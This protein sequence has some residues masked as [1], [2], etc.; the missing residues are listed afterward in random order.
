MKRLTPFGAMLA[1]ALTLAACDS[2]GERTLG[3]DATGVVAGLAGVDRGGDGQLGSN[4]TPMRDLEVVLRS[5][6]GRGV[7]GRTITRVNGVF[8][9]ENVPVGEY[10]VTVMPAA[11]PD[12]LVLLRVDSAS[13]RLGANDTTFA[14]VILTYPTVSLEAARTAPLGQSM[15]IEG[16]VLNG[17]L[18]YG[19]STMHI[20]G[21]NRGLRLIRTIPTDV[22]VGDSV[23]VLGVRGTR[24]GQPVLHSGRVF[25]LRTVEPRPA[26]LVETGTAASARDGA[27]DALLVRIAAAPIT[28]GETVPGGDLRL[29]IDDGSGPLDVVLDANIRNWVLQTVP[30]TPITS[31]T[32]EVTGLLVPNGDGTWSLKPRIATEARTRFAPPQAT[33]AR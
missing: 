26:E 28:A 25:F 30:N 23:R 17:W 14:T 11:V 3:V 7:V 6:T 8:V 21:G 27:L 33:T 31:Y 13:V 4:D 1:G 22:G 10:E 24:D 5:R 29:T 16:V 2:A 9:F 32:L 18:T 15:F 12:S 19:D 20:A